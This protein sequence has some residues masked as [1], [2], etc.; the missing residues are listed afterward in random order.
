MRFALVFSDLQIYS[1]QSPL[2]LPQVYAEKILGVAVKVGEGAV[3][4]NAGRF[5]EV[6]TAQVY[7]SSSKVCKPN[8]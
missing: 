7:E 1:D 5:V 2:S 4:H 3:R 8:H 6:S